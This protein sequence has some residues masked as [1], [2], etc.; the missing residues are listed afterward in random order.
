[1][2]RPTTASLARLATALLVPILAGCRAK[3]ADSAANA[4][5]T[6]TV[7]TSASAGDVAASKISITTT[8]EDA[9]S[10]YVQGRALADQ[11]RAHDAREMFTQA[12]ALDPNFALVH[13]DLALASPTPKE[14]F[15]HLNE[16]VARAD[17]ASDGER[18]MILQLQAAANADPTK[19][20]DYAQ[21]LAAK[22][23][24]DERAHFILGNTYVARQQYDQAIGEYKRAIEINPN[25]SP[26][27]NSLGYAY[28]PIGDN[29]NAEV[30]FKKYIALVPADPNPY[31]S[32]AELLMKTGRFDESIAQYRKA[33]S[34]D[35]H[36]GSS[37]V[38][39]ATDD[40]FKGHTNEAIGEAQQL[41]DA[42][43]DDGDRRNAMFTQVMIYVDAG[44]TA[45]A[46]K[47]MADYNAIATK[48]ADT[49]AMAADNVATGDILLDA[50]RPDEARA[51]YEMARTMVLASGLSTDV[52]DDAKL[53][54]TY[55]LAR[56]ALRKKD[57]PTAKTMCADYLNGAHARHNDVRI[58]QA[59]E[60]AGTIALQEKQFDQAVAEL[61]QA[62]QQDPF[63]LY[64]TALAYQGSG[65]TDKAAAFFRQAANA[66]T[67]PTLP[68]VFIRR[69]AVAASS[70]S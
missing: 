22:Y 29:A 66:N 28:R 62:N 58:R 24:Q 54:S 65:Q 30:A 55:D 16:A 39:I 7:A 3:Q 64:S 31:D 50:G 2:P 32:Y 4:M 21:Q 5:A 38:G 37:H 43:R 60:L 44:L 40:M 47:R 27:Y 6:P 51:H 41:Y 11:L 49:A 52:K 18:L 36:F 1:M 15:A 59:H 17:K 26:A 61:M 57:L 25:Y 9:R 48:S 14:F 46:L 19:A 10:R 42:A 68:Y 33:L 23:P 56:V 70:T 34:I 35:P 67:L 69:K 63:V 53:A 13:Y 12:A 20:L 8:S 45:K